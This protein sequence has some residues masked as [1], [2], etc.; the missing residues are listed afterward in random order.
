MR[1][2]ITKTDAEAAMNA[3]LDF[4]DEE[5]KSDKQ[6]NNSERIKALRSAKHRA[7]GIRADIRTGLIQSYD[8]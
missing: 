7:W 8:R 3:L 6:K 2:N 1:R 5:I 4:L